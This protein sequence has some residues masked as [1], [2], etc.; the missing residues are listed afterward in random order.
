[1][2]AR[3]LGLAAVAMVTSG[4][5]VKCSS[6]DLS[7]LEP[8]E[9]IQEPTGDGPTFSTRLVMRDSAGNETY[10]FTRGEL[11]TFE[12]TVRNKTAQPVDL[13]YTGISGAAF[14]FTRGG[15]EPLWYPG[16]GTMFAQVVQ[17]VRLDAN[18]TKTYSI[19]WNQE[20]PNGTFLTRGNYRARGAF[21][22]PGVF[23]PNSDF[24]YP[25]ELASQL[26]GF[27]IR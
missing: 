14:V 26:R 24:L 21:W 12:V 23:G 10:S 5:Q 17:T 13:Q 6:G 15:D 20:L 9:E 8:I 4:A 3:L 7:D 11:I 19:T 2:I 25:H 16:Y 27:T 22:A 18:E 1:M